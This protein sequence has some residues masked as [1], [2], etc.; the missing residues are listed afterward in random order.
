MNRR[1][2][3]LGSGASLLGAGMARAAV[4]GMNPALPAGTLELAELRDLPG[5][6]NLIRLADRPPNYEAPLDAFGTAITPNERFFVRYHL[7]VIPEMADLQDWKL[8]VGGESAE[9][10]FTL[11]LAEL[12]KL[13]RHEVTAV[14][15][16][17][18]NRR[19]L[20][21][22]HVA[23]VEWGV[24]AMGCARF[25]GARLKDVLA[26]AGVKKDALEVVVQGADGPPMEQTPA[27]I[28][29]LPLA[30]A[31]DDTVLLAYEMNG[32]P[33]PHF[34]GFPVRLVVP[35]WTATY[36]MKHI[37]SI[38]VVNK[39][40]D[41]FW[42]AAAYRVPRGMFPVTLPF[43][44]QD[45]APNTPITEIVVNSLVT[46]LIDGATVKPNFEVKGLAWDR[47]TGIRTVETSTDLG[48][49]WQ[50]ARLGRDHG[51]FA[52]RE[53]TA[54][55]KAPKGKVTVMVRATNRAGQVQVDKLKWNPAGYH[56]NV[57]QSLN[58]TVA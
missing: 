15:Q 11:T 48:A 35:G 57:I 22:P 18:G 44:S 38:K 51:G 6:K 29:S 13:P 45:Y 50:P 53:F 10:P 43:H 8:S 37:T 33:L 23:G 16:C 54:A 34:N 25:T 4:P 27:F 21:D 14:C 24:G 19:G 55:L 5:K 3:L 1:G 40:F 52:F 47:G 30:K 26:R 28:K 2:M 17:S 7:A 32:K 56:N 12:K 42:M 31:L 41:N 20:S 39:P 9:K 49:S 58:L 46:N 36:W